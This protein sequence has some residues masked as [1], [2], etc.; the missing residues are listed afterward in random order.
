MKQHVL[1]TYKS[2]ENFKPEL[3]IQYATKILINNTELKN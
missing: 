2:K 3:K 1:S